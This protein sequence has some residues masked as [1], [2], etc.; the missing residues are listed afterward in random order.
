MMELPERLN[1]NTATTIMAPMSRMIKWIREDCLREGR[2]KR[3]GE[4]R[5]KGRKRGERRKEGRGVKRG[6]TK[7]EE[8]GKEGN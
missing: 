8:E 2:W 3:K 1:V 7:S 5:W 4:G 6:R